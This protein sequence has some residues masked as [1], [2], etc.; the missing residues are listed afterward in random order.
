MGLHA[1][2][3]PALAG[4]TLF[5]TLA[6]HA[7]TWERYLQSLWRACNILAFQRAYAVV[8]YCVIAIIFRHHLFVWSVFSPKLLYD[9]VGTV[10]TIQAL[11]TLAQIVGL[12]HFTSWI[13]RALTFKSRL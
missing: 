13:A 5:C 9:L 1:Y 2:A 11:A 3:G 7:A 8:I 12:T 10:F 6:A 4:A